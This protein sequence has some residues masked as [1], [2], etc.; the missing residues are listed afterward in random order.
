MTSNLDLSP[1]KVVHC[2]ACSY[3]GALESF[4]PCYTVYNDIRCPECGSTN[5]EH[6]S[7]Y[8]QQIRDAMRG[9]STVQGT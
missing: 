3:F 1:D 6:N 9:D 8:Q 5:N 7:Q 2:R 4:D